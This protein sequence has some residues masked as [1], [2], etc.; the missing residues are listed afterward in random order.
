MCSEADGVTYFNSDTGEAVGVMNTGWVVEAWI[1]VRTGVRGPRALKLIA[2][3]LS[4]A[5]FLYPGFQTR[6][7]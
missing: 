3:L 6:A 7:F 2:S 1:L 4:A 5:I